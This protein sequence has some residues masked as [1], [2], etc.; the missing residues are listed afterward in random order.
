MEEN[1]WLR[2]LRHSIFLTRC[3]SHE[4]VCDVI[5]DGGHCENEGSTD[6]G[7]K[8]ELKT[9]NHP[10]PYGLTWLEKRRKQG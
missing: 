2:D 6:L 9:K 10:L 4:K 3:N 7:E 5:I 8:L 1:D